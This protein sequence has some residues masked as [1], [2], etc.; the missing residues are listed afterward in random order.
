MKVGDRFFMNFL[1][2]ETIGIG[3]GIPV[4]VL[5]SWVIGPLFASLTG[6]YFGLTVS[7]AAIAGAIIVPF[8]AMPTNF[9]LAWPISRFINRYH[10][11]KARPEE[12][13]KYFR[14][15][16]GLSM[17][18]SAMI[19]FRITLGAFAVTLA[20]SIQLKPDIY[21]AVAFCMLGTMGSF[22]A[23]ALSY[24]VVSNLSRPVLT[25]LIHD[26]HIGME[27]L[28]DKRYVGVPVGR[29]LV[30]FVFLPFL[31]QSVIL[32]LIVMSMRVNQVNVAGV[33]V[34]MGIML[35]LN[36]FLISF[37]LLFWVFRISR[38]IKNMRHSMQDL[39]AGQSDLTGRIET[40]LEDDI[41][42]LT[43]LYNGLSHNLGTMVSRVVGK[44]SELDGHIQSMF[45]PLYAVVSTSASAY[46]AVERIRSKTASQKTQSESTS[47]NMNSMKSNIENLRNFGIGFSDL[48]RYVV[49]Q[50]DRMIE[51]LMQL[52]DNTRDSMI[53]IDSG[54]KSVNSIEGYLAAITDAT[55]RV[56]MTAGEIDQIVSVIEDI[57][58]QTN[59]LSMNA[60]IEASH[61]GAYGKGF[62]VVAREIKKLA[63]Q[64]REGA[65]NTTTQ[66][67]KL[68]ESVENSSGISETAIHEI[69]SNLRV[70]EKVRDFYQGLNAFL[71]EQTNI[72]SRLK[73]DLSGIM[74]KMKQL[75]S[76]IEEQ[77][78]YVIDTRE[79][80]DG[81]QQSS[82]DIHEDIDSLLAKLDALVQS[83]Q[84]SIETLKETRDVDEDLRKSFELLR[85]DKTR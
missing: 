47:R 54:I 58:N 64:S 63:D 31:I 45:D 69:Q 5:Y 21:S 15:L 41:N 30:L 57:A 53:A 81:I 49:E 32:L 52:K 23:A 12:I 18:Q 10:E 38:S 27:K 8:I 6:E 68:M 42:V 17:L 22:V 85:V 50:V 39:V 77:H 24:V 72:A 14:R 56:S 4:A 25:R 9:I 1:T 82:D 48:L 83:V 62:A 44:S 71:E 29:R 60:S 65:K 28:S 11:N 75:I 37:I 35:G 36:F 67:R 34:N 59:V 74:T 13:D 84:Q 43:F 46:R 16:Q 2:S 79:N 66:I 70:F 26:G 33:A 20:V 3:I 55:R 73:V 40:S 51:L 80:I 76:L 61:V 7:Y 19:F 78:Q